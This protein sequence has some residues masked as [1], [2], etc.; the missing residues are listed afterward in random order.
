MSPFR[1]VLSSAEGPYVAPAQGSHTAASV[2]TVLLGGNEDNRLLLRGLLRLHHYP[3]VLETADPS[4]LDR[5]PPSA[6]SGVLILDTELTGR[7]WEADLRAAL[8]SHPELRALVI[9]PRGAPSLETSAYAAG[10]KGVLV[11]PFAI[12]DLVRAVATVAASG[13][14]IPPSTP[15]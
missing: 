5:L 6:G 9:L 7:P 2:P 14:S 4:D 10:A 3:V 12:R 15:S 8:K 1:A 13:E 11:R